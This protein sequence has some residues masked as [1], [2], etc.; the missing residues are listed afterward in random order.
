M[1]YGAGH[2]MLLVMLRR[3]SALVAVGSLATSVHAAVI[4][5]N[6]ANYQSVVASLAPGDTLRLATGTY[7][8]GLSL[9]GKAG[10]QSQPIV[11]SGPENQSAVFTARDCCNT[12]QL[13]GTSYVQ[14][15]NLTLDAGTRDGASAVDSRGNSHHILLEN[16]KIVGHSDGAQT[17]G[18]ATEG[19]A[20]NW[21]VRNDVISGAGTGIQLGNVDGTAP[22]IA[23]L[24]EHNVILDT[25]GCDLQIFETPAGS[26][27]TVIRHN[28]VARQS[29]T[30]AGDCSTLT[31]SSDRYESYGNV[32]YPDSSDERRL[33]ASAAA[34]TPTVTLSA[35]PSAIA[36]GGTTV[37]TWSSTDTAGCSASS[38]WM[39]T[40]APSGS[41]TVGPL[42]ATT[43]F[44]LTCLGTGGNANAIATVTVG[45]A[46]PAPTP[47]PTPEPTPTPTP[48]PTP[49]PTS[50]SAPAM[51]DMRSG[52][53]G[54]DVLAIGVLALVVLLRKRKRKRPTAP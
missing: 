23:G 11:V 45:D 22:F 21:V 26:A 7:T 14:V 37:L 53:G 35:S 33:F 38:G 41:E 46:T 3:I 31:A 1:T 42:Q 50:P 24:I 32:L 30:T 49:S 52:G 9:S 2:T 44:Q 12:V 51:N 54:L 47:T 25:A 27:A 48:T 29:A 20:S 8:Q 4:D 10:T 13:D 6:P 15:L 40:K 18:I 19:P 34:P 17:M 36:V 5:A 43:S 39:G 16:L 28:V